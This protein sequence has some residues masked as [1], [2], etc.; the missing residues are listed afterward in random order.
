MPA[1]QPKVLY[2]GNSATGNVYTVVNTAGNYTIVRNINLC[3]VDTVTARTVSLHVIPPSGSNTANTLYISNV[4][5]PP[6]DILQIDT[7]L[8]IQAGYSIWVTH[9]SN[10]T[11]TISGVEYS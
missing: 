8:I 10:V 6:N 7:P 2:S 1:L 11:T 4:L 9:S 3:N 5:I